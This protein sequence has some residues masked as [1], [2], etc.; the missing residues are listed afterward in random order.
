MDSTAEL[1]PGFTAHRIQTTGAE[2]RCVVGGSGPPLLL[3]HGY[4]QTHAMWH[5]VAP[6]LAHRHTVVCADLRGYGDSLE[7]AER[8]RASPR[9]RSARWRRT[10]SS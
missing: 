3:L 4:P 6:S 9:T 10:W 5:K 7:A 8:C 2:I 1:F